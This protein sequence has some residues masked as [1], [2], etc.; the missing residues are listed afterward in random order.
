VAASISSWASWGGGARFIEKTAWYP[1]P[2]VG[3]SCRFLEEVCSHTRGHPAGNRGFRCGRGYLSANLQD[4]LLAPQTASF[5]GGVSRLARTQTIT[6]EERFKRSKHNRMACAGNIMHA[7]NHCLSEIR[8]LYNSKKAIIYKR[9][10]AA[11]RDQIAGGVAIGAPAARVACNLNVVWMRFVNELAYSTARLDRES[12]KD[13]RTPRNK[14]T[15]CAKQLSITLLAQDSPLAL[16][17]LLRAGV[18]AL[19]RAATIYLATSCGSF[20]GRS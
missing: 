13:F 7:S 8:S 4:V 17:S 16:G 9:K 19:R 1:H 6:V 14:I 20:G 15:F 12:R 11:C 18:R 5:M 3:V 10:V 2:R